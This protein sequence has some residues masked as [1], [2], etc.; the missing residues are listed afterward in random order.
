MNRLPQSPRVL[1]LANQKGGVGKTTTAINLGTALAAIGEEVLIVDL[2][3]Q[4]NAS[5]GLGIDRKSRKVSTY[6]VLIG[7]AELREALVPTA[8]PRLTVAPSTLDNLGVE[9]EIA[10]SGDRAYRLRKAIARHVEAVENM[11]RRERFTYVLIDCPPSLNL[12]TINALSA[13][14][15]ILVPL[16]C[17]FFALEGLSQLLS[18]VE[19]VKRS[20]NPEL[21]IHGIVLTMYDGR[22]NL[23][24]QVVQDV[25]SNMGDAVYE[26]IIP[27]NVR[28]SE[29][30]SY[31]KPA[32]LYDLKCTGSQAYLKLASEII[33]RERRFRAVAA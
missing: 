17:E 15:S 3:P 29:A 26:T 9:L 30:P 11:A 13:S 8:V 27:R 22:N 10:G 7:E 5:T 18:T 1:S 12:L 25:R 6:D 33:Q 28:V 14:H 16:Q 31:G 2:D 32:L 19:Q 20:L 23:S 24:A 4:G 21:G